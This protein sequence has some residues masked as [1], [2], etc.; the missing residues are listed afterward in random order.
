MSSSTINALGPAYQPLIKRSLERL[1][2]ATT[3]AGD[4]IQQR[5]LRNLRVTTGPSPVDAAAEV[6][7]SP[8][9]VSGSILDI[10]V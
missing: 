8:P 7:I 6:G 10:Q 4:S 3:Q 2:T 5:G 1:D 9:A